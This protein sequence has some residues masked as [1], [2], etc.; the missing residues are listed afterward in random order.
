MLLL[1]QTRPML[2]SQMLESSR[3]MNNH[4]IRFFEP[5]I[6]DAVSG[7]AWYSTDK[8][9]K[10]LNSTEGHIG[11]KGGWKWSIGC[12]ICCSNRYLKHRSVPILTVISVSFVFTCSQFHIA[13][14]GSRI[15]PFYW[16]FCSF[17]S[18]CISCKLS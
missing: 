9:P 1:K 5:N 10:T 17:L 4:Y 15:N 16:H 12:Y 8:E 13:C 11:A 7:S 2:N 18:S 14:F 3:K 6:V